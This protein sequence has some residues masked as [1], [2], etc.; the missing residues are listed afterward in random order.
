[1]AIVNNTQVVDRTAA[2]NIVPFKPSLIGS[3]SF[4]R[5]KTVGTDSITFDV[6]DN[7]LFVLEDHLRNT[8]GKNALNPEDYNIHTL[9][10]PHYP[11]ETSITRNQL[12]GLRGFGKE[13]EDAIEGAVADELVRHGEIQDNHYEYLQ[14]MMVCQGVIS[15]T[16]YG[17]IDMEAE[18]EI[19]RTPVPFDFTAGLTN[20]DAQFR[21][22]QQVSKAGLT[23]GG[24]VNGWVVL[25]G[26]TW[27]N[28]FVGHDSITSSTLLKGDSPLRNELGLVG[29]GY[30]IYRFGNIDIILYD[31]VFTT[32]AGATVQPLP[33]NEARLIPRTALGSAFFAPVSKLSGINASGAKRF[34]SSY[35]DPKDRYV[36]MESEQ[37]TLV[38][39][40]QIASVIELTIAV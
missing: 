40:E 22:A 34:A 21:A 39:M 17:D 19:T 15:T 28:E 26:V 37:N 24:R 1:M 11:V 20:L 33:D 10:I 23:N 31:D 3:L 27:F 29:N 36:E 9:A 5:E 4:F 2:I 38:V 16:Y 8:E 14:A 18:F 12:S 6:R 35:R 32:K 13:T 25:A 7:S 30:S